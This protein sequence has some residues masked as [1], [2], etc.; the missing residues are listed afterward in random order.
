MNN[1]KPLI[2]AWWNG[3]RLW[4]I[5]RDSSPKQFAIL[6]ELWGLSLFQLTLKRALK[7]A[8]IEDIYIVA[9]RENYFHATTQA[10][11][12]GLE[13]K[14]SNIIIQPSMKE[15]LPIMSL[16]AKKIGSWNILALASDHLIPD[17]DEFANIVNSA[18]PYLSKW[19]VAFWINPLKVETGYWYIEKDYETNKIKLFHEKPNYEKAE[20]FIKNWFLWNSWIYFFEA[21]FFFNELEKIDKDFKN[22]I[23]SD[24]TDTQIFDEIKAI[25]FDNGI[26]EK[27]QNM[28]CINMPI[29]W[30]DLWSFDAI[31]E[32]VEEN[33]INTN[34][35]IINIWDSSNNVVIC[36]ENN[37]E[38][39]LIDVQDLVIVED[40]DVLLIS[41]KGS[42]QKV[43]EAIKKSSKT[44]GLTQYRPWW[45]YS[46]LT[47]WNWFKTKSINVLPGKQLSLQS[48]NHRSEHWVVAEWT[49]LVTVWEIEKIVPTGESIYIPLG[50]KHRLCNP[51]K[52]NLTVIETQIWAYLEEDDITR[53]DDDFGRK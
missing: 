40:E 49:A 34:E 16:A 45:S 18:I 15:T 3:T 22:L 7:L 4:P 17:E 42:T 39:A 26:S 30:T 44:S 14:S 12:I 29:K 48:H 19:I 33:N 6:K 28:Y 11:K 1:I 51:G 13:I 47:V 25:S 8:K 32:Y 23:L 10:Q 53:Y 35:N 9:S 36:Q 21:D 5:S 46:V 38:I 31:W 43:K 27:S 24:K 20:Q 2:L 41:K 52:I 50:S 37:K